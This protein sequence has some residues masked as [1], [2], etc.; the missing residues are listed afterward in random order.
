MFDFDLFPIQGADF[1]ASGAPSI[2][3]VAGHVEAIAPGGGGVLPTSKSK[4][5]KAKAKAKGKAAGKG[6]DPAD[7]NDPPQEKVTTPLDRAKVLA[8]SV[9]LVLK[10]VQ[11]VVQ[12]SWIDPA[13]HG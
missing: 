9:L 5:A 2:G 12:T 4:A 6:G 7:P 8:K 11:T 10:V 13:G 3:E 1:S